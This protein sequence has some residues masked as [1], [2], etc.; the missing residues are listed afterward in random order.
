LPLPRKLLALLVALTL[1]LAACGTDDDNGA[2]GDPDGNGADTPE[3]IVSLSPAATEMLFAIGAGDRVVAVDDQ[4]NHPPE[5][6]VTD[7]SGFQ[8]NVEAIA[9]H[10][11]DLVVISGDPGDLQPALEQ[12]GV[13]VLLLPAAEQIDDVYDQIE[14]LGEATGNEDEA[15][16]LVAQMQADIDELVARAPERDE[17]MTY[18]HEL[19]ETFFSV[20]SDTFV[21]AVYRLVGLESI[22]DAA[23]DTAGGYPQLSAEFILDADPEF[24]FLAAAAYGQTAD[25][26]AERPGWSELSAVQNDRLLELDQDTA[27][28]WGPRIVDFLRDVV[29]AMEAASVPAG[30][31][32]GNG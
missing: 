15:A 32:A 2:A 7:L 17:P 22:A 20:T 6:P 25:V 3:R 13:A 23:P 26:V 1:A 4:S 21:G 5:A 30:A 16:E 29:E 28:R 8:P 18:Y 31:G 12:I 27:S 11:P 19:D 14:Q 10:D 24:I 9:G